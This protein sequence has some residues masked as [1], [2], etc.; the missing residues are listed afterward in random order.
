M[1]WGEIEAIARNPRYDIYSHSMTHPWKFGDTMLDWMN[2]PTVHK[3]PDQVRWELAESRKILAE[4]LRLEWP[5]G[6]YN[7]EMVRLAQES[8]YIALFTI[9]GGINHRGDA[10][11][12]I[13][14]TMIHGGCDDEVFKEILR[15]GVYRNCE[16]Q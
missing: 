1:D 11:L 4:K 14:R 15:D 12:R 3:G 9:D 16:T 5:A 10:P 2:R 8:G 13:R 6:H 7:E